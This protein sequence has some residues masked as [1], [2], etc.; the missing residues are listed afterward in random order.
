MTQSMKILFFLPLLIPL[1]LVG[2]VSLAIL[3]K[4]RFCIT[5]QAR[6]FSFAFLLFLILAVPPP[7]IILWF[8]ESALCFGAIAGMLW[9]SLP[10]TLLYLD[11][12]RFVRSQMQ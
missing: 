11:T 12:M 1:I 9:F 10:T 3:I 2:I 4:L 8:E 5:S 6:L 7:V